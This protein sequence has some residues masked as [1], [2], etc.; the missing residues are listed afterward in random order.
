MLRFADETARGRAAVQEHPGDRPGLDHLAG[1]EHRHAVAD[2]ADHVHL[3]G[4]QHDGQAQLAVDLRQQRQHRGGGLRVQRAGGLVAQQD[5][6][7]GRQRA[8]D[9]DALLLAAGQLR[10]ILLRMRFQAHG[11]QQLGHARVDLR[12]RRAGQFQRE[13]DIAGHR[14]RGQQVEVLEDHADAPAQR[15]QAVR[16]Q[17]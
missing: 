9:A 1:I 6:R 3:V 15:A 5:L 12:L 16:V 13:G 8:G 11:L 2:T 17:R 10:R 7:A 14:A 4:D